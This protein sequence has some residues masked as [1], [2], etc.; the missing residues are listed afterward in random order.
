MS[1][2]IKKKSLLLF[3]SF[4]LLYIKKWFLTLFKVLSAL[5]QRRISAIFMNPFKAAQCNGVCKK[6][7]QKQTNLTVKNSNIPTAIAKMFQ[8]WNKSKIYLSPISSSLSPMFLNSINLIKII[9]FNIP[10]KITQEIIWK[11]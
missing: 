7:N 6:I 4:Y 11:T 2:K 5:K 8:N 3:H 9:H 1:G 10:P